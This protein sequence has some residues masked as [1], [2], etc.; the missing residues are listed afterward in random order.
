M[1]KLLLSKIPEGRRIVF[2][3]EMIP[4]FTALIL[5]VTA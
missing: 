4:K 3:G 1:K 2:K 5:I